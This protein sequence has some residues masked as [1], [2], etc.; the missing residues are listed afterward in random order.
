MT[1]QKPSSEELEL[2]HKEIAK[3][4]LT[5][6][7]QLLNLQGHGELGFMKKVIDTPQGGKYLLMFQHVEGPKINCQDL[8]KIS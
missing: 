7:L 2:A 5:A 1:E 6:L 4:Y 3:A 8:L